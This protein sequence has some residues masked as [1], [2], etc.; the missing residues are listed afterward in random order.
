VINEA[1]AILIIIVSFTN[2]Q[3][4]YMI[5]LFPSKIRLL[6]ATL[7]WLSLQ[8]SGFAQH[9]SN[10]QQLVQTGVQAYQAGDY[11]RAISQWQQIDLSQL[12]LPQQAIV[13]EN[14]ARAHQ[15]IGHHP[16]QE[17]AYW[18]QVKQVYQQLRQP[19]EMGRIDIEKAQSLTRQG[20]SSQAIQ[21]LC[22]PQ[23]STQI[24]TCQAQSA[25]RLV[26]SD[27]RLRAAGLGSLG[28][29]YRVQG[30]S[31]I[32]VKLLQQAITD[33]D[34]PNDLQVSLQN[35]LGNAL[36]RLANHADQR[37]RSFARQGDEAEATVL[38][39]AATQYDRQAAKA[40]QAAIALSQTTATQLPALLGLLPVQ[41]RLQPQD[42]AATWQRAYQIWQQLPDTE[43]KVY[44]GLDLAKA[45]APDG[46]RC[47]GDR[48]AAESLVKAGLRIAE[49]LNN[50]RARS[51]SLG[52]LGQLSECGQ[53][54][55]TALQLTKQAQYH[56]VS[57]LTNQDSLYLWQWQE[58]RILRA[59][60]Q[61]APAQAAYQA[62]VN[63]L[64]SI[65]NEL[66]NSDR[67]LQ[68]EFR[69]NI[70]PVYRDLIQ[71]QLN[72]GDPKGLSQ[73][74]ST[75]NSLKLAELQNYF[76]NDCILNLNQSALTIAAQNNTAVLSTVVFDDRTAVILSLPNGQQ[77]I[78]WINVDR[79]ELTQAVNRYRIGLET[80]Y[81]AYN[82]A[83]AQ[84]LYQWLIAPFA[85]TLAEQSIA[86]IVF[87]PDR[88]FRTV[89]L[90]ALHDGKSFLIQK[91]SIA[92]TPSLQLTNPRSLTPKNFRILALGL[93]QEVQI[94]Q[95]LFPKLREVFQEIQGLQT[96]VGNVKS[97]F[98][99]DFTRDRIARE[100]SQND[101]PILHIATHGKFGAQS[102]DT[103]IVTGDRENPKLTLNDLDQ[104]I[105]QHTNPGNGLELLAL[106]ACETAVG[107]DQAALGLA[108]VA[109]Q[110]G[111]RSAIAS[112]WTVN[113]AST[114]ELSQ[115]FYRNLQSGKFN[116]SQSL[117]QSQLELLNQGDETSHPYY[118]S[119]FVLI[120]NWL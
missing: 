21:L 89:P 6:V 25:I 41:Q 60:G 50:S 19:I 74:L 92:I 83:P 32:A 76:G 43:R 116:K 99:Q 29:A 56:A 37:S 35:S 47:P 109:I 36:M 101:Y 40:Y 81:R 64:E 53:A 103:F 5:S 44:S 98:N 71:L 68:L 1:H 95:T 49:K 107:D 9:Q 108:G 79:T 82:P 20:F 77:K 110:A 115:A 69:E 18:N 112:L 16:N 42:F 23:K 46:N 120:G 13:L 111:A 91:Y 119:A 72:S 85:S 34:A 54:W 45:L 24:E 59:Q 7:L 97:L 14:L 100:L 96:Q 117:R 67:T 38:R 93:G 55:S 66:L 15:Q 2:Y 78:H 63:T 105:R 61:A 27:R 12:P 57:S 39:A 94:S 31:A 102:E 70:E 87:V 75:A 106:T 80:F 62:S 58:G 33:A 84:Q 30:E 26:S 28:E 4:C 88:I 86:E 8:P 48:D 118:W 90:A 51:F 11:D 10:P 113:D 73:A 17:L 65:R 52:Q 22:S 3:F 104:L 114:A